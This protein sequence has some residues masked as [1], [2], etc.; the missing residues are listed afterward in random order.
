MY[1]GGIG[2]RGEVAAMR[3]RRG[4]REVKAPTAGRSLMGRRG[5]P[6]RG[7]ANVNTDKDRRLLGSPL[8]AVSP[9]QRCGQPW[10]SR[11]CTSM[12]FLHPH[13]SASIARSRHAAQVVFFLSPLRVF[14]AAHAHTLTQR[15][16]RCLRAGVWP[17]S[18]PP[19]LPVSFFCVCVCA[20]LGRRK[21]RRGG[22]A[23]RVRV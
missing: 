23:T 22:G 7:G 8:S 12:R 13:S 15:F 11:V 14:L 9:R 21:R 16:Q 18:V 20:F 2:A 1:A 10:T 19:S 4:G 3:R 17:Y 5:C 6:R